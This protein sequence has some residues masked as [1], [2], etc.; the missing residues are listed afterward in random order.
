M[1]MHCIGISGLLVNVLYYTTLFETSSQD[2]GESE[3]HA[4][5][6]I[7]VSPLERW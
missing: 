6:C 4:C 5:D 1:V 3:L 7:S 2:H